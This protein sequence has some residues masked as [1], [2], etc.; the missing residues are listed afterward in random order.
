MRLE[1][2]SR[3]NS[4]YRKF[5]KREMVRMGEDSDEFKL[6]YRLMWLLDKGMFATSE[7]LDECGDRSMQSVVHAHV[8]T[9]VVV[10][11]DA[12]AS[13]TRPSSPWYGSTG[14]S[15]MRWAITTTAS[16]TGST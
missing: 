7:K 4:N 12:A 6:S 3:E 11:I 13:R 1:N 9:P 16:S 14:I 2:R 5:V 10:G 8:L 15:R